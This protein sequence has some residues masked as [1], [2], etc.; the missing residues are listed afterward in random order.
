MSSAL[1]PTP[2]ILVSGKLRQEDGRL[3]ANGGNLLWETKAETSEKEWRL[4]TLALPIV[5]SLKIN[6]TGES[7]EEVRWNCIN[8]PINKKEKKGKSEKRVNATSRKSYR[9]VSSHGG[10]TSGNCKSNRHWYWRQPQQETSLYSRFDSKLNNEPIL[11][12]LMIQ[13]WEPRSGPIPHKNWPLT[14]ELRPRMDLRQSVTRGPGRLG[15]HAGLLGSLLLLF[16]HAH[17]KKK[18][19]T[20]LIH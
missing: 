18:C 10:H 13:N 6:Q 11:V 3:K 17:R 20:K 12:W 16:L 1:W 19:F 7:R 14:Q 8:Y 9:Q 2:R 4:E 15:I 5:S